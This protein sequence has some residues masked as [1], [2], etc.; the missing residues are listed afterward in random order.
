[1]VIKPPTALPRDGKKSVF[2]AGSIEMGTAEN[3]QQRMEREL[4]DLDVYIFNPRRDDWDATWVQSITN[5]QFHEQVTW[6][7]DA[8]GMAHVV[9]LYFDPTT[10]SPISLLELGLF[11]DKMIIYCPEGFWRKGNVDVVS[12]YFGFTQV[13][14]FDELIAAV[15]KN[16]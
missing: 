6:E 4:S 13:N 8:L 11:G 7:L 3:W 10:K 14:N 12:D 16:L 9:A 2:L 1:M 15:R 5:P